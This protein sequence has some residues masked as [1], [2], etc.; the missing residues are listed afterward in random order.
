MDP[1][2]YISIVN[3]NGKELLRECLNSLFGTTDYD[4]Y[5]VIVVDNGSTDGSVEMVNSVFE[6]VRLIE[7]EENKGFAKAH[8]QAIRAALELSADYVLMLN[9]DTR[10]I[11]GNWLKTMVDIGETSNNTGVVGCKVVEPNGEIHSDGRYF[12]ILSKLFPRI[13]QKYKYNTC[14]AGGQSSF[15]FVDDITGAVYLIKRSVLEAIGGLDE[16]YSPV[17]FEESDF[18]I[19]AWNAGFKIAYTPEARV[20]HHRHQSTKRIDPIIMEYIQQRNH[21]RFVLINYPVTWILEGLPFL[22]GRRLLFFI[23]RSPE[24]GV[25]LR[26]EFVDNPWKAAKYA[27]KSVV[28]NMLIAK[29]I[30][31]K[32]RKRGNIKRIIK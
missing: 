16:T 7:N 10:I 27:T 29:D 9:N 22:L 25:A 20:E 18:S 23:D 6:N 28:D 2:V 19:R 21:L 14:E 17:Y 13:K 30:I 4:N 26:E 31:Q 11:D 32:R 8:N 24:N 5:E 3:W 15:E 12:P 1:Q